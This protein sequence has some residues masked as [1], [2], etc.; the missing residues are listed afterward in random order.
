MPVYMDTTPV[1]Y[2]SVRQVH[3]ASGQ[4]MHKQHYIFLV[5]E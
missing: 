2:K 1:L 4:L 3:V 5:H